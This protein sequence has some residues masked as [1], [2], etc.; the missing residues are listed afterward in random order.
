MFNHLL[1]PLDGSRLA[2][3]A[4]P[5]AAQIVAMTGAKVTLLH[6]IEKNAP[7]EIHGETHLTQPEQALEYLNGARQTFF[8]QDAD[9]DTHIH[10]VEVENVARS[11]TEHHTEFSHD[12]IVMCTHGRGGVRDWLFGS[13]AQ[14]VVALGTVPVL[15]I[16]VHE[17]VR[18]FACRT[19]L[20]PIDG[21]PEHQQGLPVARELAKTCGS[22]V[23]LEFVVPTVSSLRGEN[24]AV[25][26]LLPGAMRAYLEDIE[27][28]ANNYV[29]GHIEKLQAEGLSAT[30]YVD[31]G[32]PAD[33]IIQRAENLPADIVILGTHGKAG[34]GA[35]WAGSVGQKVLSA[36]RIPMLLVPVH[37][38][39]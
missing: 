4:L 5:A 27:G 25:G 38:E 36:S 13:I 9:V 3:A 19:L 39:S 11:I 10:T 12:L 30:G 28:E 32:D 2:E 6:I 20:V 29:A 35:F 26:Q 33:I 17:K 7:R 23:Y 31:R 34:Q 37:P 14:Q 22:E 8:P 18:P 15:M 1:V 21:K 16:P 24:A